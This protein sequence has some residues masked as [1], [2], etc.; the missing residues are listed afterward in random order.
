MYMYAPLEESKRRCRI[1][2][3]LELQTVASYY[4][5]LGNQNWVLW[6]SSS[7]LKC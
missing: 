2:L 7:V 6:K 3:G 5:V 1:P 4:V